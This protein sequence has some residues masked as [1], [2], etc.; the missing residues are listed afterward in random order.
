MPTLLST[1]ND[2]LYYACVVPHLAD[3]LY[4]YEWMVLSPALLMTDTTVH[5]SDYISSLRIQLLKFAHHS[6]LR[7]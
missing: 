4:M 1:Q 6:L 3:K 7:L 5:G 2:R